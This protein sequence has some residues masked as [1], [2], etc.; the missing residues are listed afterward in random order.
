MYTYESMDLLLQIFI[1]RP[2]F[3]HYFKVRKMLF[4]AWA[5]LWKLW[6]KEHSL[7]QKFVLVPILSI[8]LDPCLSYFHS[9]K[10][11]PFKISISRSLPAAFSNQFAFLWISFIIKVTVL[12]KQC[13][14]NPFWDR[15][16]ADQEYNQ[17]EVNLFKALAVLAL[18]NRLY[19]WQCL[20]KPPQPHG[21][22][23]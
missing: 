14:S 17:A 13:F 15:E 4:W 21:H 9:F 19:P 8:F 5:Y 2:C 16:R 12:E 1:P 10:V 6:I 22:A 3:L 20:I 11:K 23:G 7:A 18:S